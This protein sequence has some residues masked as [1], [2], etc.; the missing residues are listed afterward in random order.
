MTEAERAQ[1]ADQITIDTQ[2]LIARQT[3]NGAF[4][5]PLRRT[6]PRRVRSVLQHDSQPPL[7]DRPLVRT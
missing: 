2:E 1:V 3:R 5:F 4:V 6:S 7:D